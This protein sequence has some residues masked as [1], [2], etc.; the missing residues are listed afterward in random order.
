MFTGYLDAEDM[1]EEHPLEREAL[2][3]PVEPEP[4]PDRPRRRRVFLTVYG[5]VAAVLVA[6]VAYLITFEQTAIETIEPIETVNVFAPLPPEPL[7]IVSFD[8]PLNSWEDGVGELFATRCT[9]CHG[10]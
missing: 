7:Q 9:F 1:L 4:D 2:N 5:I 3:Q 6:V 8:R 10:A